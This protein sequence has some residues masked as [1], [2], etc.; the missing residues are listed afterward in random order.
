MVIR[1][2]AGLIST[3][4]AS[5]LLLSMVQLIAPADEEPVCMVV[6]AADE[7]VAFLVD[8]AGDVI[9]LDGDEFEHPP[10]TLVGP[11]R[12]LI[13]GAFKRPG[14]LLLLLDAARAGDPRGSSADA[15]AE[16]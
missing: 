10:D 2:V 12:E 13:L 6:R 11:A 8:R 14:H 9:Q 5:G 7:P 4:T 15:E 1:P 3:L 16:A